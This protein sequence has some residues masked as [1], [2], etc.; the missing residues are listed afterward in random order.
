[1][2]VSIYLNHSE[3]MII[4]FIMK[5]RFLNYYEIILYTFYAPIRFENF[6]IILNHFRSYLRIQTLT[7]K[8]K[9]NLFWTFMQKICSFSRKY[10]LNQWKWKGYSMEIIFMEICATVLTNRKLILYYFPI[11]KYLHL[12][13]LIHRTRDLILR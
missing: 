1:M 13:I 12:Q 10:K 2:K 9:W 4:F 3:C 7:L 8:N 11:R 6:N 5:S